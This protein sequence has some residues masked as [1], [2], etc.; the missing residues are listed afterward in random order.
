MSQTQLEQNKE[1]VRRYMEAFNHE[2][3]DTIRRLT[4]PEMFEKSEQALKWVH[5]TFSDHS[6]HSQEIIAEND[7]VVVRILSNGR[8][9]G[10]FRGVT[11]TGRSWE[12]NEGV[13]IF[14]FANGSI[15]DLS[16]GFSTFHCICRNWASL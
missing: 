1:A 7:T 3:L 15:V 5:A 11:A 10:E 4:S 9:T 12:G 16:G 6:L 2:D 14:R 13:S 8:H